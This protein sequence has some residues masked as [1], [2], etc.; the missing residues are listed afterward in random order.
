MVGGSLASS[1]HGIARSTNDVDIVADIREDQISRLVSDLGEKFYVDSET[2]Q[3]ALRH[4]RSFNVI[5]FA[6]SSKFDIFP[7]AGDPFMAAQIDRSTARDLPVA[8]GLMVRCP[9]ATSEDTIL[10]KLVWYR[11]GGE[12]SERQW[13]DL[14][15]IR[16]VQGAALD[17]KYLDGWARKLKV[18]DLL[19]RLFAEEEPR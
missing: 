11:A 3:Q 12:Q 17:R 9:V 10:A 19:A 18:D 2:I 8:E 6:T 4:N 7:V 16:A 5:H 1:L 14:R 13:N 15:G